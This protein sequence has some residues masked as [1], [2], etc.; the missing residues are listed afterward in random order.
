MNYK[1]QIRIF[2]IFLLI[3][4]AQ[5]ILNSIFTFPKG[6]Q[7]N[8]LFAADQL[9][10]GGKL[11]IDVWEVKPPLHLFLISIFYTLNKSVLSVHVGELFLNIFA[12]YIFY[13]FSKHKLS[14]E[15][16]IYIS[17]FYLF[18]YY[19]GTQSY[20]RFQVESLFN[21]IL[22]ISISLLFSKNKFYHLI[23][24]ICFSFFAFSKIVGLFFL[25]IIIYFFKR[26]IINVLAGFT[27]GL[28]LI[29]FLFS[30]FGS[31]YNVLEDL[32]LTVFFRDYSSQINL[33]NIV[34]ENFFGNIFFSIF[35]IIKIS[36][37]IILF[38]IINSHKYFNEVKINYIKDCFI[39]LLPPF[40][41]VFL[42]SKFYLYHFYYFLPC[43]A[44]ICGFYFSKSI[45]SN[46]NFFKNLPTKIILLIIIFFFQTSVI[47]FAKKIDPRVI[48]FQ[49]RFS[50]STN[51]YSFLIE[52]KYFYEFALKNISLNEYRALIF[53]NMGPSFETVKN[54]KKNGYLLKNKKSLKLNKILE[55]SKY[56]KNNTNKN[57]TVLYLVNGYFPYFI[58][59]KSHSKYFVPHPFKKIYK[60]DK[61]INI[62]Y[63]S[64]TQ[65]FEKSLK[66]YNGK[67]I[68]VSNWF[69]LDKI[70]DLEKKI[71]ESYTINRYSFKYGN[72]H[73]FLYEKLN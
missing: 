43:C 10:N 1:S 38:I 44:F 17:I 16:S 8:F 30:H 6:D 60:N 68:V 56:V 2:L 42:Q 3:I 57:D 15:T 20:E 64:I 21:P 73:F 27:L 62:H 37:L 69:P 14:K 5:S 4:T 19:F 35:F 41:C 32:K 59:R 23:S 28:I 29:L 26:S 72:E 66:N 53:E 46:S 54:L 18:F 63:K 40:I 9:F 7:T 24:G 31:I 67:F 65:D 47:F 70:K 36:F 22:I 13:K 12:I 55:L 45:S 11:G 33:K 52:T 48:N 34:L 25:L 61:K 49:N 51:V 39:I 58:E 50:F 71:K